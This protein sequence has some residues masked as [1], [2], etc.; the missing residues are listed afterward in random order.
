MIAFFESPGYVM[1]NG[2]RRLADLWV[3]YVDLRALVILIESEI[4][5]SVTA[6]P[7][8]DDERE[9]RLA[10]GSVLN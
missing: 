7:C 2:S 1:I 10:L 4:D 6:F 3:H 5:R 9:F 8:D